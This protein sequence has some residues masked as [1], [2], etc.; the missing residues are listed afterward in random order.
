MTFTPTLPGHGERGRLCD[1]FDLDEAADEIVGWAHGPVDVVGA[2]IGGSIALH[3]AL[4]H[5]RKTRSLLVACTG[6]QADRKLMRARA[7]RVMAE[8]VL[9]EETLSR[10]FDPE[11]LVGAGRTGVAYARECF[12][13]ID[14]STVAGYWR[15]LGGHDVVDRLAEITVPTTWVVGSRDVVHPPD[16]IAAIIDRLPCGRMVVIDAPHMAPLAAPESFS[17]AVQEHF[18][19][20]SRMLDGM[21]VGSTWAKETEKE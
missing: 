10:W 11:D 12:A 7:D 4:N 19:W 16:E 3:F 21:K 14:R 5:P 20:V 6:A 13:S 15:A 17:M 1:G 9:M 8:G 2:L 18:G